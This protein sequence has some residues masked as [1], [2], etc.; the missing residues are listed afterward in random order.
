[1]LDKYPKKEEFMRKITTIIAATLFLTLTVTAGVSFAYMAGY[2]LEETPTGF[3][4]L[5]NE[6]S[7]SPNTSVKMGTVD[8]DDIAQIAFSGSGSDTLSTITQLSYWS[9]AVQRGTFDQLTVWISL[10]LHT[11]PNKTYLD[12]VED[13]VAGNGKTFYIQAEPYYATS[14]PLLNTWQLQDAFDATTPLKWVSNESP[15]FPSDAP[16]LAAYIS[17]AAMS[18][19][20]PGHGNQIFASREYGTLYIAAIKLR[21]GYG[22]PWV[23]TLAYADDVT[24]NDYFEDFEPA[25]ACMSITENEC[26]DETCCVVEGVYEDVSGIQNHGMYVSCV[27]DAAKQCDLSGKDRG[28]AVSAAARSG[29][30]K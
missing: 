14:Y 6:Q 20:V 10:Y 7:H 3:A 30:N 17:G 12:W 27:A 26:V 22:G 23:N 11:E 24:I 21:V 15:D 28:K 25:L 29:V 13:I 9:Y 8:T 4:T 2:T 1:M 16:P 19:P 5:S 18:W